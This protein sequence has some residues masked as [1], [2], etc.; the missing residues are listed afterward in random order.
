MELLTSILPS[1]RRKRLARLKA[2]PWENLTERQRL[3]LLLPDVQ[4]FALRV[5]REMTLLG[6]EVRLGETY[7]SPGKQK[8]AFERGASSYVEPAWHTLGNAFH[9]I[10]IDRKTGK[11]DRSAYTTLGQ[12]VRE[13]GGI[14][15]GDIPLKNQ[16][17][18][19]YY[20][21]AHVEYHPG[22]RLAE[23]RRGAAL[24]SL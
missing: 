23:A 20:D 14:W 9:I 12:I 3:S 24:A 16:Y 13:S 19:T 8:E 22:Q 10:V 5:L 21:L 2:T 1:P 6:H 15:K 7:R 17:G 4:A 18:Q 11:L